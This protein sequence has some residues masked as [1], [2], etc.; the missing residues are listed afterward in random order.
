MATFHMEKYMTGIFLVYDPSEQRVHCADMGHSRSS[1]V[2]RRTPRSIKG[3]KGNLPIG[4]E[5]EVEPA[6][7]PY[8]L[9][10]GDDLLVYGDGLI[11]QEDSRAIEFSERRLIAAASGAIGRGEKLRE[12]LPAALDAHRGTAGPSATPQ[13]DD[14]SFFCF[15]FDRAGTP[16][17]RT[18]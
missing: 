11:E 18:S 15:P 14:M 2:P 10:R 3:P 4:V 8:R 16:T 7:Y 9:K 5:L 1:G 12:V 13:Q 6:I 17:P